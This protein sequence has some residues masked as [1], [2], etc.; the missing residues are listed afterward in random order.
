M[1]KRSFFTLTQPRLDY[2]L[3]EPDPKEP[4]SIPVPS[5][6]TLL[7]SEALDNTKTALLKKGDSVE[8]GDKLCLYDDSKEYTVSPVTGTINVIDTYT[9]DLGNSA[10]FIVV[11]NAQ[12]QASDSKAKIYDLKEDMASADGCLRTLPGAPPLKI[13]AQDDVKIDTVVITC[14]DADILSTTNQYMALKNLEDIKAGAQIL[15]KITGAAKLCITVPKDLNIQGSFDSMQV[16]KTSM[17]YPSN[18][19][20][21]I[22]KDHLN[23]VLPAGKTPE[24][25]GV[26]FVTAE[27]AVSMAGAY[28][29]KSA[30]F[31][32]VVTIIG[33]QGSRYRAKA[34]IGTPLRKLFDPFSIHIN[35]QD[36]IVVGG[37]M[38][39]M[40]TYTPYHPVEPDMDTII[41][42]DRDAIPEISDT[43]CVNCGKCVRICPANIPVNI[44]VR[45]LA[46]DQYEEAADKCDLESCLECGLCAYTCTARIPVFQYIRLGKHELNKLRAEA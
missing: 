41:I 2:D 13:L 36:R 38:Q 8:K 31:E 21:M 4:E 16:F 5:N 14:A 22:L 15:K 20:A 26:C 46:A 11:K 19:P 43:A 3:V 34:T 39:G 18:L 45:Y 17:A 10:T 24:D 44:L 32:K 23:M 35:D 42:Q 28:K 33:K 6:L 37:P 12:G 1:I 9:D 27:A 25:M 40:A 30:G 7:L 29:T